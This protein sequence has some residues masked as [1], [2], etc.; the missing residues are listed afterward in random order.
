MS[1]TRAS[2]LKI[3]ID[4]RMYQ[5]SGIGRYIRNLINGLDNEN[6]YFILLKKK[7]FDTLVFKKNFKKNDST[8]D[9]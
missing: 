7:D 8:K 3:A 9:K 5:E 2:A 6:E 4:A 1:K